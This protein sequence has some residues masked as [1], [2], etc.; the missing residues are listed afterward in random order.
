MVLAGSR[1]GWKAKS[2]KPL[3]AVGDEVKITSLTR[4]GARVGQNTKPLSAVGDEVKITSLPR[5]GARVGQKTKL[6]SVAGD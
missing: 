1:Q 5:L 4:L 2:N 6:I 3:S